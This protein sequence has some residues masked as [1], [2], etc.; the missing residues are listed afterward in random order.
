MPLHLP[1]PF[2]GGA[3]ESLQVAA[4]QFQQRRRVVERG[5]AQ[6]PFEACL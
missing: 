3:F 2:V 1:A 4:E 6:V 5:E